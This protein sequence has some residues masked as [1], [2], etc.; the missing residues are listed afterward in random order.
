MVLQYIW[1]NK[2]S[3]SHLLQLDPINPGYFSLTTNLVTLKGENPEP[4][5]TVKRIELRKFVDYFGLSIESNP[6]RV[7]NKNVY[8]V[9]IGYIPSPS[10]VKLHISRHHLDKEFNL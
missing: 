3:I 5:L 7:G 9:H 10:S 8:F 6:S 1:D 2:V 4:V